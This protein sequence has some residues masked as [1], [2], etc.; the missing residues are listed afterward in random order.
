MFQKRFVDDTPALLVY[1][2][3]YTYVTNKVVH[4]VQM[5]PIVEPS[6]RFNGIANWYIVIRRVVGRLTN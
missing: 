4:G 1:H 5:G 3:V 6:D 2:P